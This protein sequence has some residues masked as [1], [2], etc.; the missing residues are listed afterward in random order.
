MGSCL[1]SFKIIGIISQAYL[2]VENMNTYTYVVIIGDNK[3]VC[4][5]NTNRNRC[6]IKLRKRNKDVVGRQ[7]RSVLFLIDIET[8][9]R[10]LYVYV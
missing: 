2:S 3:N 6:K 1:K 4:P 10:I 9:N 5:M 8:R 7:I